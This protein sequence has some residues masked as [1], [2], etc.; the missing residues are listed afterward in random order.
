LTLLHVIILPSLDV[1][2]DHALILDAL[3]MVLVISIHQQNAMTVPV[4][5]QV[6]MI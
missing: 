4:P 5:T 3:T 1:M 6:V 2:T